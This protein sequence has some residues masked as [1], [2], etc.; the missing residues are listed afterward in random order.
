MSLFHQKS[1]D[2]YRLNV[3][4]FLT[5]PAFAMAIFTSNYYDE[6]HEIK[7]IKGKIEAEIRFA[8]Y[9]GMV[10]L[11]APREV[12]KKGE[13]YDMNSQYPCAMLQ[14]IPVGNPS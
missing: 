3:T 5:L 9:G 8:Y 4:D 1:F 12:I 2:R 11:L 13:G 14:D 10:Q 7:V 6:K